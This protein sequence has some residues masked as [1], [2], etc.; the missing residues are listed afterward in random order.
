MLSHYCSLFG[1]VGSPALALLALGLTLL[2]NA[3][4]ASVLAMAVGISAITAGLEWNAGL[5]ARA[6]NQLFAALVV[7]LLITLLR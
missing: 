4:A 2:A 7:A 3:Q 5:K 6:L 1:V